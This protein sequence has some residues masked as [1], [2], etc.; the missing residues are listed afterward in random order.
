[1]GLF[2]RLFVLTDSSHSLTHMNYLKYRK[3]HAFVDALKL[4]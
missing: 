4:L 3:K 1:M 2:P